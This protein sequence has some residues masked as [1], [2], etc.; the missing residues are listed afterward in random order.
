MAGLWEVWKPEEQ[1]DPVL[2]FTI[3]TTSP[4]SVLRPIHDRMPVVLGD[5][6]REAWMDPEADL[7]ELRN[8]LSPAPDDALETRPV[9]TYVNTPENEGPEC[10]EPVGGPEPPEPLDLFRQEGGEA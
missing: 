2:T 7:G 9:S 1:A 6:A 10:I 8:L 3:L 4:N 5:D